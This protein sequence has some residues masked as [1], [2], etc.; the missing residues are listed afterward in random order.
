MQDRC[1][2]GRGSLGN[3][4]EQVCGLA[5]TLRILANGQRLRILWRL[6]TRL[7]RRY[8]IADARAARLALEV[9]DIFAE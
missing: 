3:L 5:D 4:E 7:Q 8:R 2:Q 6:A 9:R 1:A